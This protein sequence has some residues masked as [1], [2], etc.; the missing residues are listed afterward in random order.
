[1][2]FVLTLLFAFLFVPSQG[3][4]TYSTDWIKPADSYQKT[5]NMIARDKSDNVFVTGSVTS[6]NI[7][8]RKYD[9][10]GN[11]LWERTDS[12]G[13][14]SIYQKP[15]WTNCDNAK[16][17]LVVGY[18]YSSSSSWEYPNAV[19]VIKYNASGI[20]QWKKVINLS[21]VVGSSSGY[22]FNLRSEIDSKGN[23]YIGTAGTTPSG[24][25]LIKINSAGTILFNTTLNL[26]G[27]HQFASMRLKG[28]KV[29]ITGGV[30]TSFS[31]AVMAWDTA[32]TP[33]WNKFLTGQFGQDVEQ[34]G[35]GNVY[36]LTS[37]ANQ[38]SPTSGQDAVI[39]KL[40][41]AGT[42]LW[43]KNYHFGGQE[44]PTRCT[45]VSGKL[46]VIG[47][48]S[49]NSYFDWLTFQI[50][51]SG[52]LLWGTK[53]NGTAGNDEVPGFIAAK[54]N[55]EVFVTGK[56]GPEFTQPNGS[57][58]LRMVTL[59]YNSS[60][61]Q[62]W[63]DTLNLDKGWGIACTLASDSSL[64]VLSGSYMTAYHFLDHKGSGSCGIPPSTNVN[65]ITDS[66]ARISWTSVAGAYL[67][68]IRYKTS[69]AAA[70]TTLSTNLTAKTIKTLSGGTPYQYAVEAVCVSGPSGYSA[71]QTF[72]TIGA[73]YCSTGG[74]STS[75]EFLNLVWIGGIVNQTLS[76][77]GYADFTNLSTPIY[78]GSAVNGYLSG[79]T[80]PWGLL[81]NYSI[82]IDYNHD[83]DFTDPAEQVFAITTDIS[84]Y[85]GVNF[86]VPQTA[87]PGNTRMRVTIKYGVPPTPCGTY[88]G[89]ETE[90]YT[91]IIS[92]P[93]VAANTSRIQTAIYKPVKI[94]PNPVQDVLLFNAG[95]QSGTIISGSIF[96]FSGK[97]VVEINGSEYQIPVS[98]LSPG[99]Y[100]LRF[101]DEEKNQYT[102]TFV[103]N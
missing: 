6:S 29:V 39:Y 83:N 48:C 68:H 80:T 92:P 74:L 1:M 56:G 85:I 13:I 46:S 98:T 88:A 19:V 36:M 57:S 32:G 69:S 30:S 8:T 63:I 5:G 2:K 91:V 101:N 78:L 75:Q 97:K 76:N 40:N 24:F 33:L 52:T 60:G 3:Q 41:A 11:L 38:V 50:N 25:V 14:H 99:I 20:L 21:Y 18:Q 66:S 15:G 64:F 16:N 84:S 35:S 37:Y 102:G 82:W 47:F 100:L 65:N 103:K 45:F 72:T 86:T 49:T 96:D 7:Y 27:L 67:Y 90:D 55:G 95:L 73:G 62:Q 58:Y 10:F 22:S 89:G 26:G 70:W 94:Y 28:N 79:A 87:L 23:L 43:K 12:S 81:E 54:A 61:V 51:S 34:D 71:T 42:Q 17:V 9:K 77:N 59:K 4:N 31:A 44:F 53:Y 93:P